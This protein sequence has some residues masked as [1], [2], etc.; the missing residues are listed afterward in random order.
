MIRSHAG[1]RNIAA[2]LLKTRGDRGRRAT[3]PIR[4]SLAARGGATL[5]IL[6]FAAACSSGAASPPAGAPGP[7]LA[8][9]TTAAPAATTHTS[10]SGSVD[11]C[12]LLTAAQATALNNVTYSSATSSTPYSGSSTC[13]Y[14]NSGSADPVDIQD[15]TVSVLSVP[16]CWSGLQ[17]AEGPGK[18]ISGIG[19]AAFGFQIGIDIEVGSRCVTIKGLTHA[20]LMDNYAPDIAMAKIILAKIG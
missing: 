14:K 2:L 11:A 4:S 3:L 6:M 17:S 8:A 1:A 5:L 18:A 16:G 20:E 13:T 10:G 7:T 9:G 19:D 15:L 12:S